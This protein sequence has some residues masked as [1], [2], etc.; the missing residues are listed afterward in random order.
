M[1]NEQPCLVILSP[2]FPKDESDSNCLPSQQ[3][4]IKTMNR[5]FPELRIIVLAFEYPFI[6]ASY[7]W[8]NNTV[9]AFNGWKRSGFKKI[10]L[11][12]SIWSTLNTL[13]KKYTIIG[14]L[15]FWC[16]PCALMGH[17]FGKKHGIKHFCWILGQDAKK[18]NHYINKIKP[19]GSALVAIS[20]FI[21][22][23]F[24]RNHG[25]KPAQVIPNGIDPGAF[26]GGNLERN[27]DILAAGSLIPLK[28]YKLFIEIIN[29]LKQQFPSIRAVLCGKGP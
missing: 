6:K 19:T 4:L 14:I 18:D 21:Q 25:I 26:P 20:D 9:V 24:E 17:R 7:Q 1:K 15:S 22:N 23:E 12:R 28:Q 5:Q 8:N 13:R 16:G 27:T 11:F 3:A 2:G 10:F 29:G